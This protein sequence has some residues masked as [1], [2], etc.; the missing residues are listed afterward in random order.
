MHVGRKEG[1]SSGIL[2]IFELRVAILLGHLKKFICF[3]N[4]LPI[5]VEIK[6]TYNIVCLRCIS[7]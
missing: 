1:K 7:C 3:L 2:L 4:P 6:L 5:F